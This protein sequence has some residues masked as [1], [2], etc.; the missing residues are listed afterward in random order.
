MHNQV[1]HLY[2]YLISCIVSAFVNSILISRNFLGNWWLLQDKHDLK[3]QKEEK[4][5]EV[6]C[7]SLYFSILAFLCNTGPQKY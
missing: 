5:P 1:C 7:T 2:F 6:Y 4:K 3:D